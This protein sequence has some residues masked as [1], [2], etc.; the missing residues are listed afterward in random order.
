MS[1]L[2]SLSSATIKDGR[3]HLCRRGEV[4]LQV[5]PPVQ[6]DT[7]SPAAEITIHLRGVCQSAHS[8]AAGCTRLELEPELALLDYSRQVRQRALRAV[9]DDGTSA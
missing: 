7:P 3:K 1:A 2:T 6:A 5:S 8:T 9:G 4:G